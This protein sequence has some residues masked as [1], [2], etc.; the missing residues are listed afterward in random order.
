M[1]FGYTPTAGSIVTPTVALATKSTATN[2]KKLKIY[3]SNES[4]DRH[5]IKK[6]R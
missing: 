3:L 4:K 1:T 5:S 2:I 6:V